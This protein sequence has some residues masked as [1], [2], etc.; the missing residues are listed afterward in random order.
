MVI[1]GRTA[2][3]ERIAQPEAVI[4]GNAVG[5]IGE[6]RGA[7]VGSHHQVRVI[8]IVT[9][10]VQRRYQC[11]VFQVVGDVQQAGN[12][13]PVAGNRLG[14]DF[15]TA[16]AQRQAARHEAAFGTHR[17]NDRVFHLLGF[18]QAQHFGAE[19]F[20]TVRPAQAATGHV[21]EAQVHAFNPRRVDEDFKLRHRPWQLGDQVR[22]ELEAEV[23]TVVTVAIRL[24]EVGAQR[25]FD[26]VQVTTQDAV[27]VEHLH[28]VQGCQDR[29]FQ[30][31]LLVF[32]V[33][34]R[35]LARQV[36]AGLEQPGQ[37]A[38]D[39][40]VVVQGAGDIT[41]VK[42][43]ANLLQV[44]R[45]RTQQRHV[46]PWQAG[47]QYQAVERIVLGIAAYDM[48]ER[49]LQR[50]VELL[51]IQ[52]QAFASGKGEIMD[53][54][55]TAIGMPQTVRELAQHAQAEVL[56]NRQDIGQGQRR[57][58]VIQLAMQLLTGTLPQRL[59]ET[60]HQRVLFA[61]VH[62]VLHVDHGRMCSKALAIACRET[63]GEIGQ[64]L[65]AIGL[66]KAFDH[67]AGVV[68]L[69][70]A[71]GLDHFF[72][73]QQRVDIDAVF[74]VNPQNQLHAGQHRL[75]EEGPELAIRR[76][77]TLHQHLL[78]FLPHFGGIDIPRYVGQAIAEAAV[79]VLAQEH[80][81]LV[82]LLDLHD[83][84]HGVEQFVHRSLEQVVTGQDFHHLGQFLAQVSLGLEAR[85]ALD[86]CHLATNIRDHPHA[87]AV[88]RRGVQ[89]HKAALLDDLAAGIDLANRH[90]VRVRRAMHAARVRGLGERQQGRLA[91]VADGVVFDT[92]VFGGEPGAQQLGQAQERVGVIFDMT[93][94]GIVTHHKFFIA[95]EGEVVAHQ[96]FQ[97][98]FDF[99]FLIGIDGVLAVVDTGQQFLHL[100]LHRLEVSHGNPYFTQNLLQFLA[101]HIQF[102][103]VCAAIDFQVHQRLLR[104][105]FPRGALG[106]D[107]QQLA[108]AAA[109]HAQH[110]GLQ[111]MNA[112]TATVQLGTHRVHQ[113]RQVVVQDFNCR[114]GG[115]PA[116]ALVVGVEHPHLRLGRVETLQQAPRRQRAAGEVGHAPLGKFIQRNDAEE[117]L[118]EQRH[119]WQCL[120]T[121]VLRQCRLQLMLE[122]GFAGCGEERHL[123]Y[124]AWA[125]Y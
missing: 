64:H 6:G 30:T 16:A 82:A 55:L 85:A 52:V 93:A 84:H 9:D 5:D 19:V 60:H 119:L 28:I 14:L 21:A 107:F 45:V 88:H 123:W 66:A 63:F 112:V 38:G 68:V 11:A 43:Q 111:G 40:G 103:G 99:G 67:Q 80:A 109:T 44:T 25:G 89:A 42:T 81:N 114:V 26:Q 96:P 59:I 105:A 58:G 33:F 90:I 41:Q 117:L 69:P 116:V 73:Q 77:Q 74:R 121:D 118:S 4:D 35:Q 62:Q 39:V 94:I 37:L 53:P 29:L 92:Q 78:D 31:Q 34:G 57:I 65:G 86:F 23:R 91:Q 8:I 110:R 95:Q 49:I 115:L 124:S 50:V 17:H 104:D 76:L 7:L 15:I 120:F 12:K 100:G 22:V 97:E 13:D 87:L 24:V 32:E 71:A 20:F 47:S 61:E 113:K 108:F 27:F 46:A 56:Q 2:R 10:H 51:D 70:A 106:Q 54:E 101:Q 36:E 98:A 72:F 125:C 18:Y 122:V 75:R 1:T 48:H 83:R 102:G 3:S 79:R